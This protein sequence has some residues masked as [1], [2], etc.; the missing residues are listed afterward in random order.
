VGF[1]E[2]MKK[3]TEE[4]RLQEEEEERKF[5]EAEERWKQD[6]REAWKG[7]GRIFLEGVKITGDAIQQQITAANLEHER[8]EK[9]LTDPT[10]LDPFSD[11]E[12][13]HLRLTTE[14]EIAGY[15]TVP[16]QA[17]EAL[18][19]L[20]DSNDAMN[21]LAAEELRNKKLLL[22]LIAANQ[23]RRNQPKPVQPQT[24]S[25]RRQNLLNDIEDLLR[26]KAETVKRMTDRNASEEEIKRFENIYDDSIQ[27]K[28]TKLRKLLQ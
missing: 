16:P 21:I 4:A 17:S 26:E 6:R 19:T 23:Q 18:M 28:E 22:N 7:L 25:E 12:L 27:R 9:M 2:N 20:S 3:R 14:S 15:G 11:V 8:L 13:E 10:A 1:W 24:L 5:Q